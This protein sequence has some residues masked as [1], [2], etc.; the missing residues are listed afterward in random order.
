MYAGKQPGYMGG[1]IVKDHHEEH[2]EEQRQELNELMAIR[3]TKLQSLYDAGVNP[4]GEK[5]ERTHYAQEIIDNFE[6][7]E[8]QKLSLLD[9]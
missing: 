2:V 5:F 6:S 1:S 3:R 9:A 4:Y 7:L 8:G